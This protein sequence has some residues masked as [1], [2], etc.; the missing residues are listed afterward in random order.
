MRKLTADV[1]QA[2]RNQ[3]RTAAATA[4]KLR[5]RN[6]A[7]LSEGAQRH[8]PLSIVSGEV[9]DGQRWTEVRVGQAGLGRWEGWRAETHPRGVSLTF[10]SEA[11]CVRIASG[12]SSSFSGMSPN[13][14]QPPC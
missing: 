10:L 11:A 3:T 5:W 14:R 4:L 7:P 1:K 9:L 2:Q 12:I 6:E 8:R 13:A